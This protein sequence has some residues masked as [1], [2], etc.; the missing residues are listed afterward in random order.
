MI[1]LKKRYFRFVMAFLVVFPV[2][3]NMSFVMRCWNHGWEGYLFHDWVI[4]FAK[5]FMVAYPSVVFF[6]WV[7]HKITDRMNW[8]D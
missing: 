6:V 7:G 2:S 4:G 3:A 1:T 5:G 8:I